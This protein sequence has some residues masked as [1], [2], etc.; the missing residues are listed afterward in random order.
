MPY[1]FDSICIIYLPIYIHMKLGTIAALMFQIFSL[2]AQI[3]SATQSKLDQLFSKV[4]DNT[5]G[6]AI[7]II[8]DGEYIWH[9][10]YGR[11]TLEH[12]ISITSQT[13]FNIASLSNHISSSCVAMLIL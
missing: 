8:Q 2:Q 4:N 6:Y 7:G 12:P 11:A 3:P 10:G 5:P 13:A 9:S 1:I